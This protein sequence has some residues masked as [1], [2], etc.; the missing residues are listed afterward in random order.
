MDDLDTGLPG[1]L[2][3]LPD[4]TIKQTNPLSGTRV[5]TVPGRADRPLVAAGST[6][7]AEGP[8][9]GGVPCAFCL[10][11][12]EDVPPEKARVIRGSE[13]P[14]AGAEGLVGLLGGGGADDEGG[15]G[16]GGV[17]GGDGPGGLDGGGRG[18]RGGDF[19]VLRDVAPEELRATTPEFRRIPN[20]FEIVSFDYWR[21]NHGLVPSV[22]ARERYDRWVASETGARILDGVLRARR[23]GGGGLAAGDDAGL[24]FFAGGHDLVV[25][26]RHLTD[27]GRLASSGTLTPAE[28]R[29]FVAFTAESMGRLVTEIPAARHVAAFQ[30]WLAPAGASFDHLHKQLVAIDEHGDQVERELARLR[31]RPTLHADHLAHAR[32][33]G[34]VVAENAH[35]VAFAGYGHRY[36][37][38]EVWAKE[39][40]PVAE[41]PAA[42]LAGV[43]D[44]L[45]AL[46]AGTGPDVPCNEEWHHRPVD[47]DVAM[48]LRIE[49]KWRV[50]TLAGFEGGTRIFVTTIGPW[51]LR[52]RMLASLHPLA[53]DGVLAPGVELPAPA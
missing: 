30:N 42:H 45:H 50:S 37:T 16:R 7:V 14:D 10:E 32:A 49:L 21:R 46:H 44:L 3:V 18:D 28:H 39:A 40:A 4:G 22:T 23:P 31:T 24:A 34:L 29:A 20:L 1:C 53:A 25:G 43:S 19:V 33:Q 52:D 11:R 47:V 26:R 36:P 48:P 35:A 27:D 5:W 6:R 51:D 15:G 41:M 17:G 12:L 2:T 8:R 38:F 9:G 13:A